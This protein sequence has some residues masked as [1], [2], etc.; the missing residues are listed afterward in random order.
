MLHPKWVKIDGSGLTRLTTDPAADAN[1][2]WAP[3]G[4][5]LLFVGERGGGGKAQL[6]LA[7]LSGGEP[8]ALTSA[9]HGVSQPTWSPEGTR[10]A[11]VARVGDPDPK[12]PTPAEKR[13]PRVITTL[14]WRLDGIGPFDGPARYRFTLDGR[15]A[16]GWFTLPA[17]RWETQAFTA[18]RATGGAL[19]ASFG[20]HVLRLEA[21]ERS[22]DWLVECAGG[23][24]RAG[25]RAETGRRAE[26]TNH[27]VGTGGWRA[28][29]VDGGLRLSG[30][31][32]RWDLAP[33]AWLYV[34]DREQE[35]RLAW[36]LAED[37]RLFGTGER[38][39]A[40][41][42]R[43]RTPDV[44]VYEQYKQQGSRTYFPL[45]LLVS[46]AGYGVAVDSAERVRFDLGA[47]DRDRCAV[48]LPVA[49]G[50]A[51]RYLTG[52][53][54]QVL[55]DYVT[56]AGRP[57]E[58]PLWAYG[59]WMS[60]NEWNSDRRVRTV[61]E[62]TLAEDIPATVLVVEAWSDETTFY[63]FNDTTYDPVDGAEPVP[64]ARMR[65]GGRWPD[66]KGLADWLHGHGL[67]VLLWQIPVLKD[68][69][70]HPQH[71]TD[72]EHA[73][74]SGFCVT[75]RRGA[76]YRN[77][78]W[79]FPGARVVDF[80]NP[81]AREWWFTKRA[82]LLDHVGVDGFKTD[83]GEHLWGDDVVTAAGEA[84]DAAANRYPT[85]YLSAYHA[86]LRDHGHDRPVTFSRAGFTGA[87]AF[88]AHWAGDE[89]STWEAFRASLIA[90]LSAGLSGV[91]F[92]GWDLAGFSGPLPSAELYRRSV[93]MAAFCPIM[94]YH[95]ELNDY[96]E[97]PID[98]TPWNVAE[99][100]GEPAVLDTY[101]FFARVRMNLIPYLHLL[102]RQAA[103]DGMPLLRAMVL[104]APRDPE[105]AGLDDQ[106]F[107]GPDLLVAP[108]LEPRVTERRV[109][110]PAGDWYDLWSGQPVGAGWRTVPAPVDVLPVFARAGALVPLWLSGRVELGAP[111]GLP[112]GAPRD[113]SS[114]DGRLV[115]MVLPGTASR[116]IPHPVT[117][118]TFSV[119]CRVADHTMR[120]A[121][122]G[123]DAALPVWLRGP[124]AAADPSEGLVRE[125][126]L[127]AST[128]R[129]RLV[130]P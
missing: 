43:G 125:L 6:Q 15:P 96:R 18:V 88:P 66:P 114:G 111:V 130:R 47:T 75:M 123:L 69:E 4:S 1:P 119:A 129:T 90:G 40:L 11:Y 59:P 52:T 112:G 97:P 16:S 27:R 29:G 77:P 121:A 63:L 9:P 7:L 28:E 55:R 61:V 95:S 85:H 54:A 12:D 126:T 81:Q 19:E 48:R 113:R 20:D 23:P 70:D 68:V 32:R 103:T 25:T 44:R 84:G 38:F 46:S 127:G 98:R 62:R 26:T 5:A 76:S 120:V 42:Q 106:F 8:R 94:Q 2:R 104:E 10:V 89:D 3:D 117:G 93:A 124:V 56:A 17:A 92:W 99:Q 45:P 51:G 72:V 64:V 37:E 50:A 60:G 83:G 35:L 115:L 128:V 53:P 116:R 105:A 41:D 73:E 39:D 80:T 107:L 21:G 30:P 102:G 49:G 82:Y 36:A 67:R 34:D 14:K 31:A 86:F 22:L 74:R 100:T 33:P 110:L 24:T 57:T 101:R 65:H 13:K 78:G 122:D 108:V 109:Y 91:A 87:Q 71:R 79:W 58:L 118:R